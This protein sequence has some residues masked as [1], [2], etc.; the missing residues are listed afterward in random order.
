MESFATDW[1]KLN[2]RRGANADWCQV[3]FLIY[4]RKQFKKFDLLFVLEAAEKFGIRIERESLRVK[5]SN[6]VRREYLEKPD[7]GFYSLTDKGYDYFNIKNSGI[8]ELINE[9]V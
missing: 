5:L 2:R 9:E 7:R 3:F 6:Y 8:E 1:R 4:R